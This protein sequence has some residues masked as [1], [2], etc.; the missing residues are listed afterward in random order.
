M[1]SRKLL[2]A[3]LVLLLGSFVL[4]GSADADKTVKLSSGAPLRARPGERAPTITKL[5]AGQSVKI[6]AEKGRWLQVSVGGRVGWITRTQAELDEETEIV[7]KGSR[8]EKVPGGKRNK[9]KAWDAL[10]E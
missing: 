1:N 4:G 7:S 9:A 8:G 10:D 6:V 2:F 3:G 5:S